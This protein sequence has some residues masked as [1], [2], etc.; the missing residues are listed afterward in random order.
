MGKRTQCVIHQV[1]DVLIV[2]VSGQL[3]VEG[4]RHVREVIA[5]GVSRRAV[6]K[7]LADLRPAQVLLTHETLPVALAEAKRAP[8]T[9]ELGMLVNKGLESLAYRHSINMASSGLPRQWWNEEHPA[10][11]WAG[12][13]RR[14]L[15]GAGS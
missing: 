2:R 13:T 6:S 3:D 9:Q 11:E 1:R 15:Q 12:I 8:Y 10:L 14:D 4:F 5:R 7:I